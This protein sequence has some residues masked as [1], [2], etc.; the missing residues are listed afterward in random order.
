MSRASFTLGS[1][2]RWKNNL[3][4]NIIGKIIITK[5]FFII[6]FQISNYSNLV[7][8]IGMFCAA[9]PC[10]NHSRERMSN[11]NTRLYFEEQNDE[12]KPE[13]F[14]HLFSISSS[15]VCW[16]V[17]IRFFLVIIY[18]FVLLIPTHQ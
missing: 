14:W 1:S 3:P 13:S 5:T 12:I 7:E 15:H 17:F 4:Y 2:R 18:A 16:F 9:K 6:L 10:K 11:S 8:R